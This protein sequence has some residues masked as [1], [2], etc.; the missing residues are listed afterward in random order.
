MSPLVAEEL[1]SQPVCT[2]AHR[3]SFVLHLSFFSHE[4]GSDPG[5]FG[6]ERIHVPKAYAATRCRSGHSRQELIPW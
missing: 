1:H 4:T 3:S 2:V 5:M 6:I